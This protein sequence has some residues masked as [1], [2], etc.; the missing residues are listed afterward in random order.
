MAESNP[1]VEEFLRNDEPRH[2]VLDDEVL[3]ESVS[4]LQP[5]EP[6]CVERGTSLAETVRLMQ[7][8]HIGCVLVVEHGEIVGIFTERDVLRELV[9]GKVD[10]EATPV[11]AH[12]TESPEVLTPGAEI[13][14]ALNRMSLGGFRHV[15]IVD[16][17]RHPVGI[18]SVKDIVDYIVD[19]FP[20]VLNVP[21][22]PGL[23]VAR[24]REGA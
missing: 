5:A 21:P 1:E 12:M 13:L 22:E 15:P 23:G 8:R 24:S 17:A 9:G 3:R 14:Y 19:F 18:I 20:E 2:R 4:V 16:E 10:L 6:V 7:D 11:E